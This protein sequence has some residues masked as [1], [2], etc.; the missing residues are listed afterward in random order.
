MAYSNLLQPRARLVNQEKRE[1]KAKAVKKLVKIKAL[2]TK[3]QG[4][5]RATKAKLTKRINAKE[6]EYNKLKA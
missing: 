1:L 2:T 4:T 3:R 5:A 6:K